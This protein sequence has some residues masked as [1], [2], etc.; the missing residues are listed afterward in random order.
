M[1]RG[2]LWTLVTDGLVTVEAEGGTLK[3][4][5]RA[6]QLQYLHSPD[7]LQEIWLYAQ[8]DQIWESAPYIQ[9]QCMNYV[10]VYSNAV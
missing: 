6:V 7:M 4:N 8:N 3:V 1:T 2:H 10:K 5:T 9:E